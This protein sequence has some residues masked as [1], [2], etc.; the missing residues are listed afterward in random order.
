MYLHTEM[1]SLQKCL[2]EKLLLHHLCRA[3][4]LPRMDYSQSLLVA[5]IIIY[6]YLAMLQF[7]NCLARKLFKQV[8][9][10]T[11][12]LSVGRLVLVVIF[13]PCMC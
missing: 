9:P 1:L 7:F 6:I 11:N 12:I 10:I 2:V 8:I 4:Y 5:I 3:A 13:S